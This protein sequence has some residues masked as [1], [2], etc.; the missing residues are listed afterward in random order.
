MGQIPFLHNFVTYFPI[1]C[2][3]FFFLLSFSK[4]HYAAMVASLGENTAKK[5]HFLFRYG[6]PI[7]VLIGIVQYTIRDF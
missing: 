2:G 3:L 1:V 6:G 7:L 5:S 4:K